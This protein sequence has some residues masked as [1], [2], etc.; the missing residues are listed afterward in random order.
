MESCTIAVYQWKKVDG[1]G[2]RYTAFIAS[3]LVSTSLWLTVISVY[4]EC[5]VATTTGCYLLAPWC[6]EYCLHDVLRWFYMP[7][8]GENHVRTHKT[9][10]GQ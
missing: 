1:L 9:P 3:L 8:Q 5:D 6:I 4:M 10:H 2:A 7:L